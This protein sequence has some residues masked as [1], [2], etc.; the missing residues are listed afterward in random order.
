MT[1]GH[2]TCLQCYN[3]LWA[4]AMERGRSSPSCPL[5]CEVGNSDVEIRQLTNPV[6]P[7]SSVIPSQSMAFSGDNNLS[8]TAVPNSIQLASIQP[9]QYEGNSFNNV[10]PIRPISVMSPQSMTFPG[11][12]NLSTTAVPNPILPS[13]LSPQYTNMSEGSSSS[14]MKGELS[15]SPIAIRNRN[16]RRYF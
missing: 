3:A 14:S 5:R 15:N 4:Y 16:R 12:N 1:C 8:T 2:L 7:N 6:R 11:D 9:P 13:A 10:T